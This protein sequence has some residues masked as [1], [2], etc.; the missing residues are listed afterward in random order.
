MVGELILGEEQSQA[1][2]ILKKDTHIFTLPA[3]V[4][5]PEE[6]LAGPL[7]WAWGRPIPKALESWTWL[8]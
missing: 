5:G 8:C 4:F 1:V 2:A 3:S 6:D 7:N